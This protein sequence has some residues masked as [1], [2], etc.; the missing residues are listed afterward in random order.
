[1]RIRGRYQP[2]RGFQRV[3][4]SGYVDDSG[5]V[6]GCGGDVGDGR[7]GR[8][9]ALDVFGLEYREGGTPSADSACVGD[10][11]IFQQYADRGYAVAGCE[12]L[13]Q[14]A[15]YIAVADIDA[16]VVYCD[17]RWDL[18]VDRHEYWR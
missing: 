17:S 12:R 13:V 11:G 10:V 7:F 16:V 2:G 18:H 4:Q 14:E 15:S 8:R 6:C 1:M 5:V 3:Y 9:A